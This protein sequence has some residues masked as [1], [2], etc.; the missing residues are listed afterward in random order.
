MDNNLKQ[1]TDIKLQQLEKKLLSKHYS[2]DILESK[3]ELI[4]LLN[5]LLKAKDSVSVGGSMTLFETGVIDYL[6]K[7]SDIQYLDRYHCDKPQ[8]LFKEVFSSDVYITSSNALTM[9]GELYNIDGSGNRVAA[10]IYGPK[11]VIVVCGVNKVCNDLEEAKK[12]LKTLAAPAN[13]IRLN[14]DNPCAKLGYCVDCNAPSRICSSEVVISRSSI[15]DR[16][17][18]II[19]KENLGY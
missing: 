1:L 15:A 17:H 12:R 10:M 7:H 4:P 14:K 11:K 3:E 19:I 13:S 18:L 8:E 9:Q 2:V 16:I 5:K 6:E